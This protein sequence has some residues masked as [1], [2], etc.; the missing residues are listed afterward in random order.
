MKTL[1]THSWLVR[2]LIVIDA[3]LI[4]LAIWTMIV[5]DQGIAL[6]LIQGATIL[7]IATGALARRRE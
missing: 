4:F 2:T 3:L 5:G 7:V 6:F 1:S